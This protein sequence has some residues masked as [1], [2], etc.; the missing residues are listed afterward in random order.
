MRFVVDVVPS[1]D[2]LTE[3]VVVDDGRSGGSKVA[4]IEMSGLIVDAG[5]GSSIVGRRENPVAAFTEAL[6][7]A[8][9]DPKVRSVV[10]RI[11]SPGGTVTATDVMYRE[12]KRFRAE[13]QKPVVVLMADVAASGGYYLACGGDEIIAHPTTVTGSIGVIMQLISISDGLQRIGIHAEAITS[14]PNKAIG[15]P[16]APL[17]SEHR[18]IFQGMVDDFFG[19]FRAV[20]V[21][22]RSGLRAEDI[23]M[24]TDGRVVTGQRAAEIGLVDST[25]DLHDAFTAAKKRAGIEQARLV[26]YHR[27]VDY[28]GSA[29]GAAPSPAAE[30]NLVSI[31]AGAILDGQPGFYYL[32]DPLAWR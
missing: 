2:E 9:D 17:S 26:R 19:G 24:V 14:G 18:E 25:G 29:Y 31:D 11:N 4:L 13:S 1:E 20:V 30:I 28:V 3:T 32:W 12:L 5:G 23:P 21:A 10:L 7:K 6:A 8:K 27:P 16:L 15:S 22:N